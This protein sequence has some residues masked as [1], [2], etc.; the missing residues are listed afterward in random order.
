MEKV[1]FFIPQSVSGHIPPALML[2]IEEIKIQGQIGEWYTYLYHLKQLQKYPDIKSI[3][4]I[5][6][7]TNIAEEDQCKL[8]ANYTH[9]ETDITFENQKK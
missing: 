2:N 8:I 7:N 3:R 4:F 9:K 6:E 5:D 1:S